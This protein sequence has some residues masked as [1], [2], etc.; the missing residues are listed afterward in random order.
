M[1]LLH[2]DESD[3]LTWS[4]FSSNIP[5]YAILSHRWGGEEFLFDDLVNKTG[6]GKLGYKKIQFC[7]EQAARDNLQYFWVDTCCIDKWNLRELS[8]A[9]NSMFCW[10]HYAAK[11]Y[12]FLSDV[13]KS[14]VEDAHLPQNIWKDFPESK[15]F[16]RGWTLQE[17]IAPK[18]VEFF[19]SQGQRLGNKQTLEQEIHTITGIPIEALHGDLGNFEV[20]QRIAWAE[21]RETTELEDG[22]YCLL[23]IL[24]ISMML[25]Y[26]E[27]KENALKRLHREVERAANNTPFI[28]LY[29]QNTQ[30]TGRVEQL[31]KLEEKLF[32]KEQVT[33]EA[34]K[35][36]ITGI[37]G[38]GK[39][40]LVLEL[41]YRISQKYKNYSVFWITVT[42]MDSLYQDY[43][44]IAQQLKISGWDDEKVDVKRLVQL[45][46]SK[47]SAGQWLLIFD[48]A[49]DV[50][51]WTT[52]SG[53]KS[54]AA[55][56][57]EYLPRSEQG[58]IIFTTSDMETA[59]RLALQENIVELPEKD[60]EIAQMMLQ[61]G[62]INWHLTSEQQE[63]NH[64]L[65]EL[66]YL[67]LA[68]VL[69]AA[70]IN[71]NKKTLKEYLLLLAEQEEKIIKV[72]S[73]EFKDVGQDHG[74]KHPVATTWLISFEEIRRNNALAADYL[75]FMACIDQR[76]IPQSLLPKGSS[77]EK[78]KEA[79]GT[80]N[81]YSM[82][83][84]RPAASALDVHRLVHL[85]TRNWLRKQD[86]LGHWTQEAI[87]RL[88]D[89]FPD[90]G[91]G[92]RSKWRRLLP[93]A[94]Y[95]IKSGLIREDNEARAGLAWKYAEA[96]FNDGRYNEAE[97]YFLEAVQREKR[98]LLNGMANLASTYRNQGR[99]K[100]AE[101]LE[102]QV[103][104]TRKRVL[105]AEHPS[106]L[107]SMANL[108]LTYKDQGRWKEAEK[109]EV[110][111]ME[112]S[113]RVLD[114]EH[115]STLT[116]KG[117]LASTYTY[118]GRWKEAE[119]LEVQV[120]ETRKRVLGAEHPS[121]L[122][123]MGNLAS[124]YRNQGRWKEAEELEAQVMETR[125]RVLGEEHPDTLTSMGNL[126]VTYGN[127]GRWS[128]AEKLEVQVMETRK[129]VLG[130]EHPSTLTSIANLA[131]TYRNQGRWKEAE[132]LEVQ[133]METRKRLLGEEH[134]DT[135]TSM[136]NLAATYGNQGRWSEAEKLEVQVIE[137]RKRVLSAEHPDTL[138]S[139]ANLA[140]TY[141][142]Q[143]RWKEAEELEVQVMETRKRLLGE[144]HPDTLTSMGN[145]A[146]TYGNQG[147]W[148]EAEM[149]DV[150]VMKTR[151]SVLGEGHPD[152]LTSMA[153][154]ASTYMDQGRWKEAEDLR[155]EILKICRKVW[156]NEQKVPDP[157]HPSTLL[158]MAY[159]ASTYS[160]KGRW[161][162]AEELEMQV[163]ETRK[164]VLGE[165]HPDTL[166]SMNNLAEAFKGQG[167]HE[168]AEKMHKRALKLRQKV[169]GFEHPATL[170]SMINLAEVLKC[171]RKYEAA[172]EKHQQVL[173]LRQKL[174]GPEHPAT[175]TSMSLLAEVLKCLR[176]YEAAEEKHQQALDLR[177]KV[178][179]EE[180]PDTLKSMN[181]LA[182]VL[183]V[184]GQGKYEAAEKMYKRA[185]E[186][187]P[188]VPGSEH[189][190]KLLS[191]TNLVL[192][193]K[194][195]GKLEEAEEL[196]VQVMETRKR[197]LGEEHPDTLVSMSILAEVFK[198]QRKYE[199]AAE[200]HRLVLE[201]RRK[202]LGP[203]HPATL[204]SMRLLAGVL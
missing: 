89:M 126:A 201:L 36:A 177:K 158:S 69:A 22:A 117:N 110:Q 19:S 174:L 50:S 153:S 137:T 64:L 155:A 142:N 170:T 105:G 79:V 120:M 25:D 62:L 185:L 184:Q 37:S 80:L 181:N 163:M 148:S 191:M 141:R 14:T 88:L 5:P 87:T 68:I 21:G 75:S 17:L 103:M 42:N 193:L 149:L 178:L 134:P 45:H 4:V 39:T 175:L 173:E 97:V 169:L 29:E 167:E 77:N 190:T 203:E 71:Q 31:A 200:M 108:A 48:N 92:Y 57:I 164:I 128:E 139:M 3:R 182:L 94:N 52:G 44:H 81:D 107:T 49:D 10:Y 65:K 127:Q 23:G 140:S 138:L 98:V 202:V 76:D 85:T 118:Q 84:K 83:I 112:M 111:V 58:R 2:F 6:K 59:K 91:Y 24:G 78:E 61:K 18:A 121:T 192:L 157:E 28:V 113:L 195:Q 186:L 165:E 56:L 188:K 47:E 86:L 131:S 171:L 147:R 162:E 151:K 124:T 13:P 102:V 34:T 150:Q 159:L 16:T 93:H 20:D 146:A 143:G 152:T 183:Q 154:L 172:E 40:Q 125:K 63:A 38:I 189:Q 136:G 119:P 180:H 27:G 168:A 133:V 160:N 7:G 187:Y 132:E 122:I 115:P 30:F 104:E 204:A 130:A 8:Y 197:V 26:G 82:I 33:K 106:T 114:A 15:W 196:N 60:Q 95:A 67:P 90:D 176:K 70:Y 11:C 109:L 32:D 198:D 179:G 156:G 9:I 53:S 144:E 96:L 1:R 51:L 161:K 35:I 145:L 73:E 116:I 55:G 41:A 194:G 129:R 135:L 99:W 12:V 66:T 166:T 72:L 46:L 100:E 54:G 74:G 199:M 43:M 123:S 101:E